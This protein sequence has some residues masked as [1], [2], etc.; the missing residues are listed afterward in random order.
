MFRSFKE[1]LM[2]KLTNDKEVTELLAD[3]NGVPAISFFRSP[4]DLDKEWGKD[5]EFPRIVYM[6]E[7]YSDRERLIAGK[8]VIYIYALSTSDVL[9]EQIEQ[10]VNKSLSNVFFNTAAGVYCTSWNNSE[11]FSLDGE[12]TIVTTGCRVEY[13]ILSFPDQRTYLNP[14]PVPAVENFIKD[15]DKNILVINRDEL[16]DVF[17]PKYP[18]CYVRS[19]SVTN[20]GEDTYCFRPTIFKGMVHFIS[21]NPTLTREV[22]GN[23]L[24][25]AYCEGE[26]EME[27][28]AQM[29]LTDDVA[30]TT[31]TYINSA[32]ADGQTEIT[33]R[34]MIV[35]RSENTERVKDISLAGEL[36]YYAE[37]NKVHN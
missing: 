3:F 14:D 37:R 7:W 32:L 13:D 11:S 10:A 36:L 28:G 34:F 2:F 20:A 23:F 31:T 17:I 8:C 4:S 15:T 33:G 29:L 5:P 19:I 35:A 26:I 6:T 18:V 27:G 21:V 9:P 24:N 22:I 12:E 30:N 1:G 16:P 25:R